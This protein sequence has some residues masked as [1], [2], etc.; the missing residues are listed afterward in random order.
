M[1]LP[2]NY[3]IFAAALV[4]AVAS[5]KQD[6]YF[7]GG[8][9]HD[10]NVPYSTYDFLANN[11]RGLFDTLLMLVDA[12]GMKEEINKAG[13][14]FFAPTDY[15]IKNYVAARTA[16]EQ[17]IDPF[18]MWTVDSIMKYE[19]PQFADS[20]RMYIVPETVTYDDL[21]LNGEGVLYQTSNS[22]Y[23]GITYEET[24]DPA[25]G[26]NPNSSHFPRIMYYNYLKIPSGTE[27]DLGPGASLSFIRTRVQTSGVISTTGRVN[28]LENGHRL[29]FF[30]Q[31]F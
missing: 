3:L 29:F 9:L 5:C 18:R 10:P 13:I 21:D 11:D 30:R 24:N 25:L 14:T 2:I 6:D 28:V 19:L 23:V 4:L 1:K 22:D 27:P 12:S 17:N 26:Y 16:I 20:L 31:N 7:V 8:D 15:S